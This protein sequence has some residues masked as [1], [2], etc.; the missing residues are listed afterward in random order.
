MKKKILFHG[1]LTTCRIPKN[2]HDT[3]SGK[4]KQPVLLWAGDEALPWHHLTPLSC[5]TAN[6]Y[7][8]HRERKSTLK[9]IIQKE[10]N[11][12]LFFHTETF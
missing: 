8:H 2:V 11:F 3:A 12:P 10:L 5:N 4:W 9:D 7:E 1:V 6:N